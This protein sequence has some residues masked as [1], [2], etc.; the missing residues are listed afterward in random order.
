M[1]KYAVFSRGH[2]KDDIKHS[3]GTMNQDVDIHE[4]YY[5]NDSG[6][7][8]YGS[9][10]FQDKLPHHSYDYSHPEILATLE[11]EASPPAKEQKVAVKNQ[12]EDKMDLT[13]LTEEDLSS[14]TVYVVIDRKCQPNDTEFA[15]KSLPPNLILNATSALPDTSIIG[16]WAKENIPAGTRFG[17]MLG[18]IYLKNK[19]PPSVDRK[20]FWRVYDKNTNDVSF[21]VDG[22]DVRKA[23]WM[24]YVLPAY[25]NA[26]Q[27][28]VAYQ[29]GEEIFFLT[30]KPIKKE[31]E[32]TV[33]YCKEFARRLGYPATGEQMMER[34]RQK[35]QQQMELEAA[36][37]A[38]I[39]QLQSAYAQHKM[40]Q[41]NHGSAQLPPSLP[42]YQSLKPEMSAD[43]QQFLAQVKSEAFAKM[44]Q[45]QQQPSAAHVKQ[46][47]PDSASE[48]HNYRLSECGSSSSSRGPAS[49]HS[50]YDNKL[51]PHGPD[52]GYMGSPSHTSSPSNLTGS[53][54]SPSHSPHPNVDT[55][56]QVLDL[57]NIKKRAS[58]EP[59]D[60]DDYSNPFRKHK[61]KM[62][63]SSSSSEGSGSP[64]H[65]RTPSPI[66]EFQ[67]Q[68]KNLHQ[69]PIPEGPQHA[70]PDHNY[71]GNFPAIPSN[72]AYILSRRESIDAVIKAELAADREPDEDMGPEM[73]YAKQNLPHFTPRMNPPNLPTVPLRQIPSSDSISHP[74]TSKPPPGLIQAI[75]SQRSNL[76]MVQSSSLLSQ[77]SAM[78]NSSMPPL[79]TSSNTNS[80]PPVSQ[81]FL[82]QAFLG[83]NPHNQM[84]QQQP[85][86][87][88][89]IPPRGPTNL[90]QM[91]QSQTPVSQARGPPPSNLSHLLQGQ[92]PMSQSREGSKLANLLSSQT[93]VSQ[94]RMAPSNLSQMLA[95]QAPMSHSL[96]TQSAALLGFDQD[97][98][99]HEH[100]MDD[101]DDD[102]SSSDRGHKTLPYPLKKR[103][104]KLEYR[105]D[106]CDKLFGQLSNLKV[107]LRTHSG[108]RPFTCQRC[109]KTFTQLA[110]L[111]KHILVHTGEKPHS[112]PE[113]KKRFSSTSNLKTHMRLHKGEKPFSCEK[114]PLSF[115]QFVH[116]KLHKRL[117]N[118][119]RP[120]VCGSCG[121][122]Y[123][124]AS[125]LR[126]HW[127][128]T[129]CDPSPAEE[130]TTAERS[131]FLMQQNDQFFNFKL[132]NQLFKFENE[133]EAPLGSP[134]M[135]DSGSLVMDVDE[136]ERRLSQSIGDHDDHN[137]MSEQH[138][139]QYTVMSLPQSEHAE[140]A[141]TV[142]NSSGPKINC[143][144]SEAGVQ[145]LPDHCDWPADHTAIC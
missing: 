27:N 55:S 66:Q 61:M 44:H 52:S 5:G 60:G 4:R 31:E 116:L 133:S 89:Y 138:N 41:Q 18:E 54:R 130:A 100:D 47:T 98:V 106:T 62:H 39:E 123:I 8:G 32:L 79:V 73:F 127:K 37:R 16:V 83:H 71:L 118:N 137:Q 2:N 49:P 84:S 29:D 53:P 80:Q 126:T 38:A 58:P 46:E 113:C 11:P 128:T 19:V 102:V 69:E 111:Q 94:S 104:N 36:K 96:L 145:M 107:H 28:L 141:T 125:G 50:S 86:P 33:W 120:F 121:K 57:T 30:I 92:P 7:E 112:C 82:A 25:K 12:M 101:D 93:P 20:Y 99:K 42:S 132:E 143:Q 34:V 109:P 97:H 51:S 3:D 114:C 117:H 26:A 124:S 139:K 91:L 134:S 95:G 70:A 23:N 144:V 10:M 76:Q 40:Q 21:F 15:K 67:A 103:D 87:Q 9:S 77:S 45:Q 1:T 115:T 136:S 17:P 13:N 74:M 78:L 142:L 81:S 22:K 6:Y 135:S 110:H 48:F 119:E 140:L 63:K 85:K 129:K 108:E 131:L 59:Y 43:Q 64:E 24:R 56:Y 105:C 35:E 14:K 88:V 68:Y 75:T 72:P 90:S 65:R 122:S